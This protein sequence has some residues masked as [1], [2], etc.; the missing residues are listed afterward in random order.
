[1]S[2]KRIPQFTIHSVPQLHQLM[3][4]GKP[5]HPL[6]SLIKHQDNRHSLV[7]D[8]PV[9]FI[10]DFYIIL[11]KRDVKGK[12][13]YGQHYYDFDEGIMAMMAPG[14][15][16]SVDEPHDGSTGW[17]LVFHPDF[18]RNY[19]LATT[20]KSYGFFSYE[21]NEALHLSTKEEKM[22]E[23]IMKNI[24]QEYLSPIDRFSQDV[25]VSHLDLLLNYA[26]RFYN[27]QFITRKSAGIDL[28]TKL[29]NVLN[30]YF[31]GNKVQ[32]MG[33]P[34]VQYISGQ[35]HISPNYLSDMLRSL[36][37]QGTQQ[38]IHDK[39]IEKAKDILATTNLSVSEIAYRLG[40]EHS[41][42][43]SR[44]FKSRTKL[45]PLAFRSSFN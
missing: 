41:Q 43:F 35:L 19:P 33:L 11:L 23:R 2:N 17:L 14:Q 37:G 31:D 44:L 27:R 21:V 24:Q 7:F 34:S 32:Q 15:V 28:L 39:L 22:L 25:M 40:F 30:D 8:G 5:G 38:H 29:E 16:F 13:K 20:I 26:N 6:I 36:T 3:G 18:I 9:S 4:F 42:S 10:T 12:I 45:T 1:M